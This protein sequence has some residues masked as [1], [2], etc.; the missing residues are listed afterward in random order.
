MR[1]IDAD[2]FKQQLAVETER[3]GL[4][5]ERLAL[6]LLLIDLQPTV[7]AVSVIDTSQE[8]TP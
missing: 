2:V 8:D 1:L 5:I 4:N 3:Q 6:L 7:D